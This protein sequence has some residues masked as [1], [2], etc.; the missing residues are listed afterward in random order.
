MRHAAELTARAFPV[1]PAPASLAPRE[2]NWQ[3]ARFQARELPGHS[4]AVECIA[5][6][7]T[8]RF[9][10]AM[11]T[12]SW[13]GT[14]LVWRLSD[15]SVA[16][17]L[18]GGHRAWVSCLA[19]DE[20]A[21]VSG[22]TDGLLVVWALGG[23]AGP[24]ATCQHGGAVTQVRLFPDGQRAVSTCTDHLVRVWRIRD[25]ALAATLQGHAD[26][27]WCGA[28]GATFLRSSYQPAADSLLDPTR[29]VE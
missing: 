7:R 14:V 12:G 22:G 28:K 5:F 29:S 1:L 4:W 3:L 21:V 9:G 19:C 25:G 23:R 8:R 11:V 17:R 2:A 27:A 15:H 16:Q 13:D 18:A 26:V 6:Q 20:A 10:E 24:V